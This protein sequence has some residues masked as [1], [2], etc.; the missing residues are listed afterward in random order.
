LAL[1]LR[2]QAL[3]DAQPTQESAQSSPEEFLQ[4]FK[5]TP[6]ASTTGVSRSSRALAATAFAD[7]QRLSQAEKFTEA[8]ARYREAFRADPT[9][10]PTIAQIALTLLRL[11]KKTEAIE[12]LTEQIK[13]QPEA[14]RLHSLLA[15]CLFDQ[16][17]PKKNTLAVD[18]ARKALQ[19]DPTLISNY[20][21]I[22]QGPGVG[23]N[24]AKLKELLSQAKET[25]SDE[26][27]FHLRMAEMWTR[28]LLES[29]TPPSSVSLQVLPF[30]EKAYEA[31]PYNPQSAFQL[32]QVH[33]EAG[34]YPQAL[35]YYRTAYDRNRKIPGLA[36]RLALSYMSS[37]KED[38]A[39]IILESL[40]DDYPER[41]NL[42]TT[43]G[44]L[45]ER[46]GK[47][48]EAAKYYDLYLSNH[49]ANAEDYIRLAQAQIMLKK[50]DQALATMET[51]EL[52]FP[53]LSN[54]LLL[55]SITLRSLKRYDSALDLL[56]RVEKNSHGNPR[57]LTAAF[58]FQY[59]AT[60]EE[61]QN[62]EGSEKMLKRC[63]EI[64]PRHH[65]ALNYLGYMW[66]EQNR[67][68]K[69]AEKYV[70]TALTLY[71]ENPSYQD[72]LGWVYYRQGRYDQAKEILLDALKKSPKSPEIME[73]L[74]H[75]LYQLGESQQALALWKKAVTL[76]D[77]PVEL[78]AYIDKI[79]GQVVEIKT[80]R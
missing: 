39:I 75:T 72:S 45:Y 46:A 3:G 12:L 50:T 29:N 35:K 44:E 65:Q 7:G 56:A 42:Y 14:P 22:A 9:Y 24:P 66:A 5:E 15:F 59:G 30:Y 10:A 43:I 26:A 61:A 47:W 63:L 48:P 58:Y 79:S 8:L 6:L 62:L 78:Q 21:I 74:G 41:K 80:Q 16:K 11:G 2:A 54:I 38:Q 25:P 52:D 73:H 68:L 60:L 70:K 53:D 13:F 23:K 20:R 34:N 76:S 33:F 37:G 49:A 27:S 71:P 67:N 77:N 55:K 18:H 32:G 31:D 36:E 40:L 28:I 1:P 51:A 64:D 19:L 4:D 17:D 69:E 57:I